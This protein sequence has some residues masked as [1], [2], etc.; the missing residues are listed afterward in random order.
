MKHPRV[1]FLVLRLHHDCHFVHKLEESECH[2]A[3]VFIN[4]EQDVLQS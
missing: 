4:Q 2:L 3:N 1:A